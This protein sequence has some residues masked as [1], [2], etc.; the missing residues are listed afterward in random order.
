MCVCGYVVCACVGLTDLTI[1]SLIAE[2]SSLSSCSGCMRAVLPSLVP[3]MSLDT[4]GRLHTHLEAV[5]EQTG[6]E[7]REKETCKGRLVENRDG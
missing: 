5:G 7:K 3:A 1:S 2:A 6:G 4:I